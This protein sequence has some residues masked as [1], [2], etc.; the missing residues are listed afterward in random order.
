MG[1]QSGAATITFFHVPDPITEDFWNYID[2]HLKSGIFQPCGEKDVRTV[3]F[4][5]WHDLFST[6]LHD[7]NYRKSEYIAFQFRIDEKK[8]PSM[9]LK[10]HLREEKARYIRERGRPPTRSEQKLLKEAAENRLIKLTFPVPRGCEVVW[11]PL[12]HELML[13]TTSSSVIEAFLAHFEKHLR[14]FP[15]PLYHLK[16]ALTLEEVH[17]SVKDSITKLVNPSSPTAFKE[18]MFLGHD[19]LTWLWYRTDTGKRSVQIDEGRS[20]N[21]YLGDRIILGMPFEESERIICTSKKHHLDEARVAMVRGKRPEEAQWYVQIADREYTF[22]LDSSLWSIRS[23]KLYSESP[24]EG[25]DPETVFLNRVFCIEE[26]RAFLK[27][28]Y[29][30]FLNLRFTSSWQDDV[31]PNLNRWINGEL[32]SFSP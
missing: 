32:T 22:V 3:G 9:L 21:I 24:P 30:E 26:I 18:G 1:I 19:F 15:I 16:L 17:A 31:L 2:E 13:G 8:I 29:A 5:S 4:T 7:G 27:K 12:N 14:L 25:N 28:L 23:L 6:D 10:Q 11:N 20:G